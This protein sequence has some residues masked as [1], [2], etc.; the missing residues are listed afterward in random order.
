MYEMMLL[1][2]KC[3]VSRSVVP[4]SLRPD[5]LYVAHQAPLSMEFSW[6]EY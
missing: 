3:L 1:V 5:G 6:Q 4:D 2:S